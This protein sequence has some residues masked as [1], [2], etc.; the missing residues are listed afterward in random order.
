MPRTKHAV[1]ALHTA[2]AFLQAG[3]LAIDL[4]LWPAVLV[5]WLYFVAPLVDFA[6]EVGGRWGPVLPEGPCSRTG[7]VG[8]AHWF[9]FPGEPEPRWT[10][11]PRHAEQV[12]ARRG[13][14]PAERDD[15]GTRV[16][17]AAMR[18]GL[19]VSAFMVLGMLID[20]VLFA[21]LGPPGDPLANKVVALAAM[22]TAVAL[23]PSLILCW[24]GYGLLFFGG[25]V[26]WRIL[27]RPTSGVR[28]N[29]RVLAVDP[30]RVYVR[31]PATAARL[32][33]DAFGARL[34]VAD[35][36]EEVTLRGPH[37]RLARLYDE[38]LA[39]PRDSVADVETAWRQLRP[40]IRATW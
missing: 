35:G 36:D 24:L 7:T 19:R 16:I 26:G 30:V 34:T 17:M 23:L 27:R 8:P 20:V 12:R 10:I 11:D 15:R 2:L 29:G 1:L 33:H 37:P 14:V 3:I 22:M 38:L 9:V 28:F 25:F 5:A 21:T 31:G 13:D 4:D 39:V 32:T 40:V 18:T 6:V